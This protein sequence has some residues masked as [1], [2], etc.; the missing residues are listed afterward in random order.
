MVGKKVV[1]HI[2]SHLQW[3]EGFHCLFMS[4]GLRH[5][6]CRCMYNEDFAS[7]ILNQKSICMRSQ[8]L[9]ELWV[10]RHTSKLFHFLNITGLGSQ[11]TYIQAFLQ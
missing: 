2:Y 10:V 5:F 6:I 7:D 11:A 4:I 3:C 1:L 8:P 9:F